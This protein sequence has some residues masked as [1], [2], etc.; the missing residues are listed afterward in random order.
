MPPLVI[1]VRGSEDTRDCVHRAVQ[2]LAEGKLVAFPTETVYALA[3]SALNAAAVARL[4]SAKRAPSEQGIL[5]LGIKSAGEALD[6]VPQMSPLGQRLA[7]RCWPGPVTM[8]CA[9]HHPESLLARLP[10]PVR[11]ALAPS[12]NIGLSVPWHPMFL[13]TL[14]MIVGPV[15]MT[16]A[17]HAGQPD[18]LTAQ[19]VVASLGDDVALVLDDGRTR[20]GQSPSVVRI[21]DGHFEIVHPGVVSEQTLRRLSVLSIVFV[22][23]GNTCRSP[24][25]EAM[26]RSMLARRLRCTI[27]ELEDRGVSV[28]SAG[29]SATMGG[30]PSPEGVAVLSEMGID[31]SYHESQ[32]LG[33]Q[34]IRHA[35]IIW[36]M[37]RSHRQVILSQ[38]PEAAGRVHLLSLDGRDIPDPIG[39]P[40]EQYRQC[41]ELIKAELEQRAKDLQL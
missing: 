18:P 32:P 10:T 23:T 19:E 7:R 5:T 36:T 24:M 17:A 34:L 2:A 22:C 41:A 6:Y 4:I 30:R 21:A 1:D 25:A 14:K 39:G 8:V 15:A 37:T 20:F 11:Q 26:F 40:I 29:I 28:A 31:L 27:D 3:A 35:D 38:C 12:G 9:D 16:S 13:D 33:E